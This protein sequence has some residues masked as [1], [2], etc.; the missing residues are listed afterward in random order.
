LNTRGT[1]IVL[2]AAAKFKVPVL[3]ASTSEVYGKNEKLPFTEDSDRIYGSAY[4]ARWGYGMSK[5]ADEFLGLAYHREKGLPAVIVRLFNVIGP[6]QTGA[7]GMVAPRFI[8]QALAGEP[9]TVYGDGLQTRCFACVCDVTDALI[10]L[11]VNPK[12]MGRIF[13]LGSD[14][15]I[16]IKD[17]AQKVIK[18]T[19]SKSKIIFVPYAKVY[20]EDFDD[21]ARRRPDLSKIKNLIGYRPKVFLEEG[22]KRIIDYHK[23]SNAK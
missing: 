11:M 12:A 2:A 20:G 3:I 16:S 10:K 21:M 13:N 15:E 17:L 1:E 5:G 9:I 23:R 14:E 18:L 6:R 19:G 8:Q 7:Y 4:R 22:L